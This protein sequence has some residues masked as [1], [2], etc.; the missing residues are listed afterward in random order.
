MVPTT[1]NIVPTAAK[2]S[3][4]VQSSH[5][6]RPGSCEIT[7]QHTHTAITAAANTPRAIAAFSPGVRPLDVGP[8][9]GGDGDSGDAGVPPLGGCGGSG[10]GLL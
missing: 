1:V 8:L 7:H 9:V 4:R 5:R 6:V 10:D 3:V 2:V